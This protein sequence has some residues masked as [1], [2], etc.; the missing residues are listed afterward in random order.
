MSDLT[1]SYNGREVVLPPGRSASFGRDQGCDICLDPD[2]LWVSRTAGEFRYDER[3]WSVVNVSGKRTLHLSTDGVVVPLP[4]T[5]PPTEPATWPLT[6]ASCDLHLFG[7]DGLYTLGLRLTGPAGPALPRAGGAS[8]LTPERRRIA[9]ALGSNYFLP[10]PEYDPAPR[11]YRDTA[12]SLGLPESKVV[13]EIGRLRRILA[14]ARVLPDQPDA[15][16]RRPVVEWLIAL[17]WVTAA[18]L[19]PLPPGA[20]Q[21]RRLTTRAPSDHGSHDA[22]TS[23]LHD[24]VI[25]IAEE[26]ARHIAPHLRQRLAAHYGPQ[27]STLVGPGGRPASLRDF[28]QCLALLA[29]DQA[30]VGWAVQSCRNDARQLN[31][32]ANR[33]AHRDTLDGGDVHRARLL[34]AQIRERF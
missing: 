27:W 24:E 1:V 20:G 5:L 23:P 8:G 14:R 25:R 29:F 32:L 18:D 19:R 31:H 9:A 12:G 15:D 17:G 10:W 33:A 2:D 7:E 22:G 3:G 13:D 30:T 34:G 28:R 21:P 6:G 4:P 16:P 26:T 11:S